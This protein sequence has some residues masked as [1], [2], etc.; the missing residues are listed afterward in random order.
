MGLRLAEY[1]VNE[2]GFA[3][4]L[5]F[6]KYMDIVMPS[7]GIKPSA[8]VLVT[9]VQSVRNQG[10]GSLDAGLKNLEKHIGIVSG[11][12]LPLVVAINRFPKDTEPE[13]MPTYLPDMP[14]LEKIARLAGS[15]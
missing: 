1:V 11:F 15:I 4:D 9:T 10:E 7:S 6:E 13:L 8:A 2:T 14:A 12:H 3:S 5:G